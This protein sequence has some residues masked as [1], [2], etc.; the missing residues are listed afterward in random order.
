MPQHQS[1]IKR[2]RQNKKR[3]EHNRAQRSKMRTLITNVMDET[4]KEKAQELY[5]KA[6]SY[7]DK[8]S[9]KGILHENKAARKKSQMSKHINNL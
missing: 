4:D 2:V 8:M 6:T 3:R 5:K 1:A 7:V 9:S